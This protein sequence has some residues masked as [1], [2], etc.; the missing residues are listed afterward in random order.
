MSI[1]VYP[2]LN[3]L[4]RD[5][6]LSVAELERRIEQ[7]FGF[8]VNVKTL[9]RFTSSE[10]VQRADLEIAGAVASV[11][12]VGLGDLFD[13]QATPVD[14]HGEETSVLDSA[15]SRRLADLFDRQSRGILS[16]G[17]QRELEDLVG[18]YGRC[19]HEVR[20]REYA[21]QRDI[22]LEEAGSD[23][24]Q[25]LDRSIAW[26]QGFEADPARRDAIHEARERQRQA[27][28]RA[29]PSPS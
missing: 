24:A 14:E 26:W 20:V 25:D 29:E 15:E 23:M 8:S 5:K 28:R 10:R 9:Y 3:Q 4:L 19:L 18:E 2:R 22:S 21:R 16:P 17:E 12:G 13:V 11:L 1:A 6:Q 7:R 27:T